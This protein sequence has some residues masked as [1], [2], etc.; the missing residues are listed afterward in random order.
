MNEQE[1]SNA[2]WFTLLDREYYFSNEVFEREA[3]AIFMRQWHY[4]AHVSE[5]AATGD[6]VVVDLLGESIIISRGRDGSLNAM[7]NGCRHRGF[8]VCREKAGNARLFVCGYHNWA[9]G[10]DGAL[11]KA[12]S[13]DDAVID[14][15]KWGLHQVRLEV[16][17]GLIFVCLGE[18]RTGNLRDELDVVADDMIQL[19]LP[20]MQKVDELSVE[21]ETNWKVMRENFQE[22]YHCVSCHPEL[23]VSLDVEATY[24]NTADIQRKA[25]I[26]GG[27][28]QPRPGMKSI[29]MDGEPK[30][31]RYLGAFGEPDAEVPDQFH[32][33]FAIHPLLSRGLFSIDYGVIHTMNPISPGKVR[34]ITR[35]FVH[36]DAVEGQ[37]YD[38]EELT[39][40]WRVSL[41]EDLELVTRAYQGM[42]SRRYV[43]G[44]LSAT[45]E[46]TLKVSQDLYLEMMG[47]V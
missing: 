5:V 29:S 24:Q 39:K 10:L 22:C 17:Q 32:A 33:G 13:I 7:L 42:Q 8:P 34:W 43:P 1:P 28:S 27:G 18:P 4:V 25:E 23:S 47:E 45:R 19:D 6:F 15:E 26:Y 40:L 35:W 2:P 44:P 11:R 3:Q 37:D 9:Y 41:E 21:I 30:C 20:R 16:W 36:E 12:P 38:R 14:Y 31:S 46:P